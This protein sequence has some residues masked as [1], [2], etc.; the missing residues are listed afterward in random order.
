MINGVGGRKTVFEKL[1]IAVTI[2]FSLHFFFQVRVPQQNN[3]GATHGSQ[4]EQSATILV[5]KLKK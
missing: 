5:T 3:S 1:L 4:V 2:T